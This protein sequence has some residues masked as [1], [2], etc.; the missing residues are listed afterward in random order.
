VGILY[1]EF[2]SCAEQNGVAIGIFMG[3]TIILKGAFVIKT[4]KCKMLGWKV[5]SGE[6][7]NS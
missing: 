1:L 5:N 2:Y 7:R 6:K 3:R 4:L